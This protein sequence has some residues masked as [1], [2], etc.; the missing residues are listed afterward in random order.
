M[1]EERRKK[2]LHRLEVL[3]KKFDN[4]NCNKDA[5]RYLLAINKIKEEL[6]K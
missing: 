4:A 3:T 2:L 6:N 5:L 1:T